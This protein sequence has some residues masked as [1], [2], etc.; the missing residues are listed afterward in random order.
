[1]RLGNGTTIVSIGA[2]HSP[3]SETMLIVCLNTGVTY[4]KGRYNFRMPNADASP[5]SDQSN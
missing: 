3:I 5:R 2:K 4:V 1:M